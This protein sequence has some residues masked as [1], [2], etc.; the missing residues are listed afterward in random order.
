MHAEDVRNKAFWTAIVVT[1]LMAPSPVL[2]TKLLGEP[3]AGL[4]EF[5]TLW[6]VFW[7]TLPLTIAAAIDAGILLWLRAHPDQYP[8][9][10]R[11][12]TVL[13]CWLGGALVGSMLL[14]G[15]LGKVE[16]SAWSQARVGELESLQ[17][18]IDPGGGLTRIVVQGSGKHLVQ[19]KKAWP[20]VVVV[21]SLAS[22]GNYFTLYGPAMFLSSLVVGAF[23]GWGWAIKVP[24]VLEDIDRGNRS[25]PN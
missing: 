8:S 11:G 1:L 2:L 13:W 16:L 22:L 5:V 6:N 15:W 10:E 23:L 18:R 9:T 25:P 21:G 17:E 4:E 24:E 7:H 19:N 14:G 3:K 12:K 20:V